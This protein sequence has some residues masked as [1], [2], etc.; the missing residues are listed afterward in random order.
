MCV[1]V[2]ATYGDGFRCIAVCTVVGAKAVEKA[3]KVAEA[4]LSRLELMYITLAWYRRPLGTRLIEHHYP[5]VT[6]NMQ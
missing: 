5:K 6:F 1:Q 4:I 2:S 3:Y